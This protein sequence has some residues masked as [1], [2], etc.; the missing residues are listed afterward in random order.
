MDSKQ[1]NVGIVGGSLNNQWASQTHIPALKANL[2]YQ[3]K[4]I[5]TSNMESAMKSAMEFNAIPFAD[6]SKLVESK[7]VD[8]VVVSVKVPFHYEIA[9]SAISKGKHINCEWPLGRNTQEAIELA[10]LA[11]KKGIHHAVGLQGRQSPEIS[12]LKKALERN[13]IGKILSCTM[14]VSTQVKGRITDQRSAYLLK[15]ENGANL[16]T[17]HGG[18][19][20]DVLCHTL[21][22]F[23]ELSA[24][25]NTNYKEAIIR[26]T[27]ERIVKDTADQILVQGTLGDNISTSIHIQAGVSPKFH[28]EIRGEKGVFRLTQSNS[29][30]HVQFGNL[31]LEKISHPDY[32]GL[33]D[34]KEGASIEEVMLPLEKDTSPKEYIE[35]AYNIF[36][37]DILENKRK[38]PNF[39]DAV[40]LH[41]LLD[42]VRESAKSGRKIIITD[43]E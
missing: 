40:K 20:L 41:R 31:R 8:L 43:K 12:Y 18:H 26:E 17:I 38:I 32:S 4:A 42:N 25:M 9:K 11:D 16:L 3:I 15:E 14:E 35:K 28:L 39:N 1:I 6:Y 30:G 5:G 23:K 24:I 22:D 37:K 2:I 27:G 21:G 29:S 34:D 7:D 36:A 19:A 33:G 13:E 10:K